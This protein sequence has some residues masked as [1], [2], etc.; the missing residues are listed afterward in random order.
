MLYYFHLIYI[1]LYVNKMFYLY[2][3]NVMTSFDDIRVECNYYS[4]D[5]SLNSV[6]WNH[7]PIGMWHKSGKVIHR[8]T[9]KH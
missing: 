7:L 9:N 4:R 5:G 2:M 3:R 1:R 8:T 6:G